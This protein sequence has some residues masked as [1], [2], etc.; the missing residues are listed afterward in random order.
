MNTDYSKVKGKK[1]I[2]FS[3]GMDCYIINELETPDVLLYI[4]NHSNYSKNEIE[5]IRQLQASGKFP[6]L[7]IVDDFINMSKTE[8]DDYIIPC[9]NAYFA[10][11]AAEYGDEIILGAT[12]GDRPT[13]KCRPFARM[14]TKLLNHLY[15]TPHLAGKNPDGTPYRNIKVNLKYKGY[16]KEDLIRALVR[17]RK[18]QLEVSY[19]EARKVV[20]DELYDNSASCYNFTNNKPCGVCKSCLR[21][22]LAILGATGIDT[23]YRYDT[24]PRDYFTPETI[25]EW[26]KKETGPG[27]RGKESRETVRV[28]E[29]LRS[30]YNI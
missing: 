10:M 1:L 14:M 16:S 6:N 5:H 7:I 3:G 4:D 24:H 12:S 21:K 18:K 23:G 26:I 29:R 13:D 17:K 9:R 20:A 19:K 30:E 2:L 27:N 22:W 25:E 11:I 15:E 8:R 28:L